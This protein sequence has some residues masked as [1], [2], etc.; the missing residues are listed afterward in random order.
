MDNLLLG[1]DKL[2]GEIE[3]LQNKGIDA[4]MTP[5]EIALF[6]TPMQQLHNLQIQSKQAWIDKAK[7]NF[8]HC[9]IMTKCMVQDNFYIV[10][11]KVANNPE[12]NLVTEI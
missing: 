6:D 10:D 11:Y 1:I 5:D 7:I 12:R 4:L 8:V 2:D 9:E 3:Y